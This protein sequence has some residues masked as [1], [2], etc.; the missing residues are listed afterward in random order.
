MTRAFEL[1]KRANPNI[2]APT[3]EKALIGETGGEAGRAA[4]TAPITSAQI[5]S[6]ICR[7][8]VKRALRR[9]GDRVFL[10]HRIRNKSR[11]VK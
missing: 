7:L 10:L 1:A 11:L 4:V 9:P 8:Q 5:T 2:D 6:R 3:E